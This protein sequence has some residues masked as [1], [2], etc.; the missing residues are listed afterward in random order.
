MQTLKDKHP[1]VFQH[2]TNESFVVHKTNQPFSAIELDQAPEQ[3][4]ASMKGK[5]KGKG[6]GSAV[7]LTEP[8]AALRRWMVA[9]PEIVRMKWMKWQ[10]HVCS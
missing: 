6:K 2:S 3:E 8:R 9:G 4:N 7:G 1:D 5:G 10:P